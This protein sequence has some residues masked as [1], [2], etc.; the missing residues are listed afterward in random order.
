MEIFSYVQE[1]EE[2]SGGKKKTLLKPFN[3]S[4]MLLFPLLEKRHR[5]GIPMKNT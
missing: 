5:S 1:G 2:L 4:Q 3:Q